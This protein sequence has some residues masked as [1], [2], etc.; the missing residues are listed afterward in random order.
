MIH[1]QGFEQIM[2]EIPHIT[3]ADRQ[4]MSCILWLN[5]K[6]LILPAVLMFHSFKFICRLM[7]IIWL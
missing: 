2:S 1:N 5:E 6:E 3:G 4:E 7:V